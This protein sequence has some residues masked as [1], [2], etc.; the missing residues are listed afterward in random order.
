MNVQNIL[1]SS[2]A[3]NDLDDGRSFYNNQQQGIGDYF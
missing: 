1:I 2:D 3:E